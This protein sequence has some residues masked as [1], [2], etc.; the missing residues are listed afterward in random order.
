MLG[1]FKLFRY[2]NGFCL[3]TPIKRLRGVNGGICSTPDASTVSPDASTVFAVFVVA[4]DLKNSFTSSNFNSY[5]QIGHFDDSSFNHV[6]IDSG[7]K[8]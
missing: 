8:I 3:E 7:L 5:L 2:K 4:V 6:L 1:L